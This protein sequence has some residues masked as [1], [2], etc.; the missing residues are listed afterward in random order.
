MPDQKCSVFGCSSHEK[1]GPDIT[2]HRFPRNEE[3]KEK[4][5]RFC[6]RRGRGKREKWKPHRFSVV[7][8]AHFTSD[9]YA[10]NWE[11]MKS[12]G[13][14]S[15][16]RLKP[17]ALPTLY[18]GSEEQQDKEKR[19]EIL[20]ELLGPDYFDWGP[21]IPKSVAS[22]TGAEEGCPS[23]LG[24]LKTDWDS[25]QENIVAVK[26]TD[27]LLAEN[28]QTLVKRESLGEEHSHECE[29]SGAEIGDGLSVQSSSTLNI[30]EEPQSHTA[31]PSPEL[32]ED[33]PTTSVVSTVLFPQPPACKVQY[34]I[35]KEV[36]SSLIAPDQVYTATEY[37]YEELTR[38][39]AAL[40][41]EARRALAMKDH[42]Y[43]LRDAADGGRLP[44]K[45]PKGVS[46]KT[47]G[48]RGKKGKKKAFRYQPVSLGDLI[49]ME[50]LPVY[51]VAP[52]P[53]EVTVY[54]CSD[55]E[56]EELAKKKKK[57]GKVQV[58]DRKQ[59]EHSPDSSDR[60]SP[61]GTA[62]KPS[63]E[64]D[65]LP[66]ELEVISDEGTDEFSAHEEMDRVPLSPVEAMKE[67]VEEVENKPEPEEGYLNWDSSESE[68]EFEYTD[69]N[70]NDY[71]PELDKPVR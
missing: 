26:V 12:L 18:Q 67:T 46:S 53:A 60:S 52:S 22:A 15:R 30:T 9:Q 6:N 40:P 58:A 24:F 66:L 49:D 50:G 57:K 38:L 34:V 10:W 19:Q 55:N 56:A 54:I 8:S 3:L 64:D 37:N 71:S 27:E 31:D 62:L 36:G 39:W 69:K 65:F 51:E 2:F 68:E 13:Y 23:K 70:D 43:L 33:E 28:P 5:I 25:D 44:K 48:A 47:K 14:S 42:N 4:W 21:N 41:L 20:L 59:E 63:Q 11:V 32:K 17:E 29:P 61:V 35:P 16:K 7:C 45:G 1:T